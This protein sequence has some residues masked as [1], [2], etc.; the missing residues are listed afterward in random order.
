MTLLCKGLKCHGITN[1]SVSVKLSSNPKKKQKDPR[2]IRR[3]KCVL[4]QVPR[5]L[6]LSCEGQHLHSLGGRD[7]YDNERDL[8]ENLAIFRQG[9]LKVLLIEGV[10]FRYVLPSCMSQ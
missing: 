5:P 8:E 10:V 1:L 7:L 4:S 2:S 9:K 6:P 3:D